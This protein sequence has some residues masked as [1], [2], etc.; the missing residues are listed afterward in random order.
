MVHLSLSSHSL[1]FRVCTVTA[2]S[3]ISP[4]TELTISYDREG[5]SN[6]GLLTNWGFTSMAR[7]QVR[8]SSR[9][10]THNT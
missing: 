1:L 6:L 10:L 9:Q 8:H 7:R 4:G 2:M 3:S 5:Q